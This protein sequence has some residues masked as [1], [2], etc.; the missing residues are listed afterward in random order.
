MEKAHTHLGTVELHKRHSVMVEG[1]CV[2]RSRVMDQLIFDRYLM[3]GCINLGQ[4]RAAEFLL[5]LSAKA[6]MW[7]KG[8]R[9]DGAYT[10]T[11]G[12]SKI[13]FGMIPLGD[14][15]SKIRTDCS[16]AHYNL[17]KVVI[18]NNYDVRKREGGL[19]VFI[20]SMDYVNDRIM[21]Y[22]KNPLRHLE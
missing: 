21:M 10:D 12:K 20:K 5:S 6:G 4:H 17:T 2:P 7:A 14:V 3:E 1:G 16:D 13:F 11:P 9:L 18:F 15:L 8:A 22:H 19:E